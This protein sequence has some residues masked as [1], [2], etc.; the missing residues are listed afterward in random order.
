MSMIG[1]PNITSIK[2][3]D[4]TVPEHLDFAFLREAGLKHIGDLSGRI[5]TDHNTHDPGVTILEVLCYAMLDLGYR[6]QL[7]I[8]DL[9]AIEDTSAEDDNFFTAAEILTCN[10]TTITDYRKLIME[11]VGVKN[12][13]LEPMRETLFYLDQENC[14]PCGANERLSDEHHPVQLN[15]LYHVFLELED[16]VEEIQDQTELEDKKKEII[17]HVKRRLASHRNLCEDFECITILKK[18]KIGICAEIELEPGADSSWVFEQILQQLRDFLSPTARFYTLQELLN[19]GKSIEEIYAGRPYLPYPDQEEIDAP[20]YLSHGFI[21]T[22]ELEALPLRRELH[23]SDL[24]TVIHGVSGV[25]TVKDLC[26]KGKRCENKLAE[27]ESEAWRFRLQVDHLAM[28]NIDTTQLILSNAAGNLTVDEKRIKSEITGFRK[29]LLDD[30]YLDLTV[31]AGRYRKGL[32]EYISIQNDL[33]RVYSIGET[34][35]SEDA[36][37]LRK[38]QAKQLQGFLLFFDQLLADYLQQLGNLRNV[39]SLQQESTR[40]PSQRHVQFSTALQEK[41]VPGIK[42]LIRFNVGDMLGLTS[43]LSFAVPVDRT[44]LKDVICRIEARFNKTIRVEFLND[45]LNVTAPGEEVIRQLTF[46]NRNHR[47]AAIHQLISN[48]SDGR[49]QYAVHLDATSCYF[50]LYP[51]SL[52]N[53]ALV[54]NM[55]FESA[56]QA[57]NAVHLAAFLGAWE[58]NLSRINDQSPLI[59]HYA[60][61]ITYR[62]INY[63]DYLQNLAEGKEAYLARR[64][65]FLNHLLQRFSENFSDYA[66]LKFNLVHDGEEQKA[67][68]VEDKSRF[69]STYDQV[70]RDRGKAYAYHLPSW[71]TTN[72]SG[73]ER[74][75]SLL[76]GYGD[77]HRNSLCNIEIIQKGKEYVVV[78]RDY[79]NQSPLLVSGKPL[80]SADVANDKAR[81]LRKDLQDNPNFRVDF[82]QKNKKYTLSLFAGNIK[83][84]YPDKDKLGKFEIEPH[85][86][87]SEQEA[88][89][90]QSYITGFHKKGGSQEN[91]KVSRYE[92][93]HELKDAQ[94]NLLES[95]SRSYTSFP[96]AT[97][98]T[99][100]FIRHINKKRSKDNGASRKLLQIGRERRYVDLYTFPSKIEPCP[101]LWKWKEWEE[102]SQ[103]YQWH[104]AIFQSPDEALLDFLSKTDFSDYLNQAGVASGWSMKVRSYPSLHSSAYFEHAEKARTDWKLARKFGQV[105]QQYHVREVGAGKLRIELVND[106]GGLIGKTRDLQISASK[107]AKT[108]ERYVADFAEKSYEPKVSEIKSSWTFSLKEDDHVLLKSYHCYETQPEALDA[109]M[110]AVQAATKRKNFLLEDGSQLN[111]DFVYAVIDESNVFLAECHE[112]FANASERETAIKAVLKYAKGKKPPVIVKQQPQTYRFRLTDE[113]D[114]E[115]FSSISE[116]TAVDKADK[117]LAKVL[118]QLLD[119]KFKTQKTKSGKSILVLNGNIAVSYGSGQQPREVLNQ[120]KQLL[121]DHL[122]VVDINEKVAGW[123][124]HHFWESPDGN[125]EPIF[126]SSTEFLSEER[127]REAYFAFKSHLQYAKKVRTKSKKSVF[128]IAGQEELTFTT[129]ANSKGEMPANSDVEKFLAYSRSIQTVESSERDPWVEE[130]RDRSDEFYYQ[131]VKQGNPFAFHCDKEK[132]FTDLEVACRIKDHLCT[133]HPETYCW[134]DI[135]IP[136]P[137]IEKRSTG[138]GGICKYHFVIR[139]KKCLDQEDRN[140]L[141]SLV[142]YDTPSLAQAAYHEQIWEILEAASKGDHYGKDKKICI[143]DCFSQEADSCGRVANYL[144]AIHE[145]FLP[146][147]S[148]RRRIKQLVIC[149]RSFPIKYDR[150]QKKF[151]FKLYDLEKLETAYPAPGDNDYD[152]FCKVCPE[153]MGYASYDTYEESYQEFLRLLILL[154]NPSNCRIICRKGKFFIELVEVLM[155]SRCPYPSKDHA[156]GRTSCPD[157]L[158]MDDCI[159]GPEQSPDREVTDCCE[160]QSDCCKGYGAELFLKAAQCDNKFITHTDSEVEPKRHSFSVVNDCYHLASHPCWYE[161]KKEVRDVIPQIKQLIENDHYGVKL[162]NLSIDQSIFLCLLKTRVDEVKE[163]C[164]CD[165]ENRQPF[166]CHHLLKIK[167]STSAAGDIWKLKKQADKIVPGIL[168]KISSSTIDALGKNVKDQLNKLTDADRQILFSIKERIR[169]IAETHARRLIDQTGRFQIAITQQSVCGPYSFELVDKCC[170]LAVSP[171]E[172]TTVALRDVA[173]ARAKDCVLT[174]GM[175][176][177]EHILLRPPAEDFPPCP[178]PK[179][180]PDD[181][182]EEP[183]VVLSYIPPKGKC[184][185]LQGCPD[186]SCALC[187]VDNPL[188][189]DPCVL[190][191]NPPITYFPFADAYSFWG[192]LLL[193]AWL[194]RFERQDTRNI[195]EH[196]LHREAPS[197]VALNILWLSP[198]EMCEFEHCYRYWLAWKK[199]EG[200]PKEIDFREKV[201][202]QPPQQA[203]FNPTHLDPCQSHFFQL[204]GSR[205]KPDGRCVMVKCLKSLKADPFCIEEQKPRDNCHCDQSGAKDEQNT[206]QT[207]QFIPKNIL[208]CSQNIRRCSCNGK[209]M[210]AS[211]TATDKISVSKEITSTKDDQKI[212]HSERGPER[213]KGVATE[214]SRPSK[215]EEKKLARPEVK[216]EPAP[217]GDYKKRMANRIVKLKKLSKHLSS[218]KYYDRAL[219]FLQGQAPFRE[220]RALINQVLDELDTLAGP[221]NPTAKLIYY[222]TAHLLDKSIE[223]TLGGQIPFKPNQLKDLMIKIKE[224]GISLKSLITSWNWRPLLSIFPEEI[225]V[226]YTKMIIDHANPKK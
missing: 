167:F 185:I 59:N 162:D 200:C 77:G 209:N 55:H 168:E 143:D 223:N 105:I 182:D 73:F 144:A 219:F 194:K 204:C 165:D 210:H 226:E 192:T 51:E 17:S 16:W 70:S 44:K 166:T 22:E 53:V 177:V 128:E 214:E 8:Q 195:M 86:F 215:S 40:D 61:D 203:P 157:N 10:P 179:P 18:Q 190:Q 149:F 39:F 188:E 170:I 117:A 193:P 33:P 217:N 101:L 48:L 216:T 81:S 139:G 206:N 156:W 213:S 79:K 131:L 50:V 150:D 138:E 135:C 63:Q 97:R 27:C 127:A 187:W 23:T 183:P 13:W 116:Y 173:M 160:E 141:I 11:T 88:L 102:S 41:T 109:Y 21:D 96:L 222:T 64:E 221:N 126:E 132:G 92:Y 208:Q 35:L 94:G 220:Y 83:C 153:W 93:L 218:T 224:R 211:E 47:E 180:P 42:G 123:R 159:Q 184:E 191:S 199:T 14:L 151:S 60:F 20:R 49:Y 175:H 164:G 207:R 38:T 119:S 158:H 118:S 91:V 122:L 196:L 154:R 100:T 98:A 115:I 142:G 30:A 7:P 124:F 74:R 66:A 71:E 197:H 26:L 113:N 32:E 107:A 111:P 80:P 2:Q 76:A 130:F 152:E 120:C 104:A 25:K 99:T 172:Y 171:I 189:K 56:Y 6:A 110:R 90:K 4:A 54:S 46:T 34:G 12:A 176:L 78:L 137:G 28:L 29:G 84:F 202:C 65:I 225:V 114:K 37:L 163:P 133:R 58:D 69:L 9:L 82:D 146:E 52:P 106:K 67:V 75:S 169:G 186:C 72:V 155:M 205:T 24:Y 87:D 3:R 45:C 103:K 43:G 85:L 198:R 1:N 89:D 36:S 129:V 68:S 136:E 95:G 62:P 108:I 201:L 125:Y 147:V 148:Y 145:S 31:P 57:E 161:T 181:G 15:G 19:K 134:F 178:S 112:P 121:K 5:W 212:K 174:E 140:L